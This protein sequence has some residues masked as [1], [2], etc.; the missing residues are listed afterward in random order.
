[1]CRVEQNRTRWT[2]IKGFEMLERPSRRVAALKMIRRFKK[3]RMGDVP[4]PIK[5]LNKR[6]VV[7]HKNDAWLLDDAIDF[8][9]NENAEVHELGI[10]CVDVFAIDFDE[11]SAYDTLA[12][13]FPCLKEAPMETTKKGMHVFFR[14]TPLLDEAEIWDAAR[15]MREN[16]Q[17]LPIDIKTATGSVDKKTGIRTSGIL[18]VAPSEGK[19]WVRSI[20]DHEIKPVPPDLARWIISCYVI[21]SKGSIRPTSMEGARVPRVREAHQTKGGPGAY[22]MPSGAI[23]MA[24]SAELDAPDLA[25]L[26]VCDMVGVTPVSKSDPDRDGN[27]TQMYRFHSTSECPMC[28]EQHTS[29][30]VVNVDHYGRR[31]L[32]SFS[33]E[34][35]KKHAGVFL[36]HSE[37]G[38]QKWREAFESVLTPVDEAR[39]QQV[40]RWVDKNAPELAKHTE[41]LWVCE[42]R[43]FMRSH[44]G[45][46]YII[47][48]EKMVMPEKAMRFSLTTTRTPWLP[49]DEGPKETFTTTERIVTPDTELE[50]VEALFLNHHSDEET[51]VHMREPDSSPS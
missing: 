39:T 23:L 18:V 20:F 16:G 22:I 37:A 32:G 9:K 7:F 13:R 36:P 40:A 47:V 49:C 24:S 42:D 31:K 45:V 48:S 6:P 4:I 10:R 27:F 5:R 8:F 12:E 46:E 51:E 43:A 33:Y 35:R 26:G 3:L 2:L 34:C 44:G 21:P 41:Q 25:S 15:K 28:R 1:M 30:Y 11:P 50:L 17:V 19:T 14:R 29:N 38:L